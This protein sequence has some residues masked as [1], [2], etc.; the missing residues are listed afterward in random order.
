VSDA[1]KSGWDG[2]T[3]LT[4]HQP[5]HLTQRIAELEKALSAAM[6]AMDAMWDDRKVD[7]ERKAMRTARA[8][9]A[10]AKERP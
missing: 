6:V 2:S 3:C 10:G 1:K 7:L 9:L 8:A 4:C 5:F